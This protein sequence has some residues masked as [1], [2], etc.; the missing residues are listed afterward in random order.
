MASFQIEIGE[1]VTLGGF[2]DRPPNI[3]VAL[4]KG[5]LIIPTGSAEHP[6]NGAIAGD[7]SK[8]VTPLGSEVA[9]EV[10]PSGHF[11]GVR[12]GCFQWPHFDET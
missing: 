6:S 5:K 4:Q 7:T 3:V 8:S 10:C 2:A 9:D 11:F 1:I 12:R